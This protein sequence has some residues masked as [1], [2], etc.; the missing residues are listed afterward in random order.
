M[1]KNLII[2]AVGVF[3]A[4]LV[5]GCAKPIEAAKPAEPGGA[6]SPAGAWVLTSWQDSSQVPVD[7]ITLYIADGQISGKSACN[8]YTGA[9]TID[10]SSFVAGPLAVTRMACLD[11][12]Q[13]AAE[14]TYLRLIAELTTWSI[15]DGQLVLSAGATETL[16][17]KA[18]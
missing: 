16:R 15:D 10:D 8:Q 12:A 4:L 14:N 17:F 6:S 13:T 9:A 11:D 18:G 1:K 5:A 3:L 2:A 7:K